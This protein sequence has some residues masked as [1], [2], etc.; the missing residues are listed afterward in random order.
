[1]SKSPFYLTGMTGGS[2]MNRL[3]LLGPTVNKLPSI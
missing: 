1:M 3:N 2:S